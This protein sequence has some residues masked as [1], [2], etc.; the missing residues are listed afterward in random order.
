M[1]NRL[2]ERLSHFRIGLSLDKVKKPFELERLGYQLMKLLFRF[3]DISKAMAC[4]PSFVVNRNN[5][6]FAIAI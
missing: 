5:Q 3:F 2:K 4:I 1:I 6:F